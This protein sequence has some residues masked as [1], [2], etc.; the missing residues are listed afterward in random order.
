MMPPRE[1]PP[2][3]RR[4]SRLS[5]R[6]FVVGAG[7]LGLLAGCGRLPWQRQ[8]AP[9]VPRLGYLQAGA[10][11]FPTAVDRLHQG[12]R[13]SGYVEGENLLIEWRFAAGQEARMHQHAAELAALPVDVILTVGS[14]TAEA[15]RAATT[16]IPIVMIYPD[17]PVAAGLVA[18]LGR[19]GGNVTG[20]T[21]FQELLAPKRLQLLKEAVPGVSRVALPQNPDGPLV[22]PAGV[23]GGPLQVAAQTLGVQLLELPVRTP[24]D[25]DAALEAAIGASADA[26]LWAPGRGGGWRGLEFQGRVLA[27]AAQY[28]LP[29]ICGFLEWARAGVLMAYASNFPAEFYRAATYI[30]K[31]LQGAKPA[32]LPVEQPMTFDFVVNMKTA[33]ELGITF[34]NEIMLQ[35][36][37]VS[38]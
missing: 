36:T 17:D 22:A 34:P 1:G 23:P 29:T 7:G 9:K 24:G 28:R 13:E 18:S 14:L 33:R 11:P 6:E 37:E 5:R 38:Q 16:T 35:V 15:A 12:L 19:P 3:D 10:E 21:E 20:V 32:D 4:G 31:I 8:P 30:T 26:I 25:L 27:L 2:M